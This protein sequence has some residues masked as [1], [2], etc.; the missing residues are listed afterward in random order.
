MKLISQSL[1]GR[2]VGPSSG[3]AGYILHAWNNYQT[4]NAVSSSCVTL[5]IFFFGLGVTITEINIKNVQKQDFKNI[6]KC[7]K[8]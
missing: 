5:K 3:L 2:A 7:K 8:M 6:K 4:V 1:V